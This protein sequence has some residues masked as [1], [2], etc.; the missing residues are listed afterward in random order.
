MTSLPPIS[1]PLDPAGGGA[2]SKTGAE[3]DAA[4]A[5]EVVF[6][7]QMVD[8]MMKTV[9]MGATMGN[10]AAEMWRS[11]LSQSLAENLAENGGLGIAENVHQMMNAYKSQADKGAG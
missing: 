10:H 8:E 6:L 9:D 3:R 1:I 7:G 11:V 2:S 4:K 5:F